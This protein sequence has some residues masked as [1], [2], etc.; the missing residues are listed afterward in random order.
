MKQD[1]PPIWTYGT[2][3]KINEEG[4]RFTTFAVVADGTFTAK[5]AKEMFGLPIVSVK[6][7]PATQNV[8]YT[9]V[10]SKFP[11][12]NKSL[13]T[14]YYYHSTLLFFTLTLHLKTKLILF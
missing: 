5:E 14:T 13:G 8:Y 7:S 2:N 11:D 12:A 4:H 9:T 6:K 1:V 10:S 3:K